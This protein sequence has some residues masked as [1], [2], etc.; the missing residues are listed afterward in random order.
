MR[1]GEK[2]K[3]EGLKVSNWPIAYYDKADFADESAELRRSS[4]AIP[5]FFLPEARYYLSKWR[6]R[7]IDAR[8]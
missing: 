1:G 2:R 5:P 4:G 7:R 6:L 8:R 3:I